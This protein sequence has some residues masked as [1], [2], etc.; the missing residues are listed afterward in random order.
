MQQHYGAP[1]LRPAIVPTGAQVSLNGR[2]PSLVPHIQAQKAAALPLPLAL[3]PP[4]LYAADHARLGGRLLAAPSLVPPALA[5][6]LAQTAP[7]PTTGKI[8]PQ[9]QHL[10]RFR[11][12]SFEGA[13]G[14][15]PCPDSPGSTPRSDI[16]GVEQLVGGEAPEKPGFYGV[17]AAVEYKS[18]SSGQWIPAKVEAFSEVTSL[19]RLNV[20]PH[21]N[22]QRVRAP[23]GGGGGAS[24]SSPPRELEGYRVA[25]LPEEAAGQPGPVTLATPRG[26]PGDPL[27]TL[28]LPLLSAATP[29]RSS[30]AA[31]A[32][33]PAVPSARSAGEVE[34]E[35]EALRAQVARLQAENEQLR[36]QVVQEANLKE[37]YYQELR[38]HHEQVAR[39]T[40]RG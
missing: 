19:Y 14:A 40:Q 6:S 17:G 1:Q 13:N 26:R 10:P 3:A 9:L 25:E 30:Y 7:L 39:G 36:E 24:A 27:D 29:P 31:V 4:R 22:P 37:R 28:P 21:A 2:M 20:Q 34:V 8:Q 11:P 12:P 23:G 38:I 16:G 5:L 18:R 32:V 35:V 15:L 33:E